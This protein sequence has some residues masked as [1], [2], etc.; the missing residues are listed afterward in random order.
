LNDYL[1]VYGV[2][3]DVDIVFDEEELSE[4]KDNEEEPEIA[5]KPGRLND[6]LH[7]QMQQ[8][9]EAMLDRS[10]NGKQ[11]RDSTTVVA[12][13]FNVSLRTV[14]GIWHRA[15]GC[16]QRGEPVDVSSKKPKHIG[17]EK[18]HLIFQP[19]LQFPYIRGVL[20]G[21]LQVN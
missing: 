4:S 1:N 21:S 12:N 16:R 20:Y 10:I 15:K 13:Q 19:L 3:A 7:Q 2:F 18:N 8:I 11:K 14:Q 17:K 9:Y 6:V 5:N